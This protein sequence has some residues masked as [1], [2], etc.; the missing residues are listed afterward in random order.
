VEAGA[1]DLGEFVT[2]VIPRLEDFQKGL[3]L[4]TSKQAIKV[5]VNI[6]G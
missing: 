6:K 4:I 5:A 3:D 2:H 1:I